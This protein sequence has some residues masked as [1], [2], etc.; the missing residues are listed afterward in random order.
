MKKVIIAVVML[1]AVLSPLNLTNSYLRCS[2]F[3]TVIVHYGDSVENIASRY[4]D[5]QERLQ[6]LTEAIIEIN[7]IKSD[8]DMKAGRKLQ[9]P[10]MNKENSDLQVA[11]R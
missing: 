7:D 1:L 8:R 6:E 2:E 4:T 11:S 3:D 9:I 5:D 10:V